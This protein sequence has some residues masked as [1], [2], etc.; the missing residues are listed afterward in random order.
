MLRIQKSTKF[1]GTYA[2]DRSKVPYD[3]IELPKGVEDQT[4]QIF[5]VLS[6]E[7][8]LTNEKFNIKFGKK[9]QKDEWFSHIIYNK[10]GVFDYSYITLKTESSSTYKRQD[11]VN[12][13]KIFIFYK[14]DGKTILTRCYYCCP[15]YIVYSG[16]GVSTPK[17]M[18]AIK[19]IWITLYLSVNY[20]VQ[21]AV[22][23]RF[24]DNETL[25]PMF[26]GTSNRIEDLERLRKIF[27]EKQHSV[28]M[29]QLKDIT[30]EGL[31]ILNES[32]KNIGDMINEEDVS[33][34]FFDIS[35][36]RVFLPTTTAINK[37]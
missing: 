15:A 27:L 22:Q 21:E 16:V 10:N 4:P 19:N 3:K 9:D 13:A 7:N 12:C 29:S 20:L 30:D 25:D 6:D 28:Q 35:K 17:E 5:I 24:Y 31:K 8:E 18:L 26:I 33:S 34:F 32:S 36:L 14:K 11:V 37:L 2:C 23:K 1:I